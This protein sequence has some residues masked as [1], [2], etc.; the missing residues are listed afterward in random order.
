MIIL[1]LLTMFL[2]LPF[3]TGLYYISTGLARKRRNM[4]LTGLFLVVAWCA[5]MFFIYNDLYKVFAKGE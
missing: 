5:I 3:L 2:A 4:T 1:I